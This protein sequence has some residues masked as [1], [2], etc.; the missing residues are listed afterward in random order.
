ML[1]FLAPI[2]FL[3]T[4]CAQFG[5]KDTDS[6]AQAEMKVVKAIETKAGLSYEP[7]PDVTPPVVESVKTSN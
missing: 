3:L 6:I 1:K 5:I 2:L 7:A 4:S